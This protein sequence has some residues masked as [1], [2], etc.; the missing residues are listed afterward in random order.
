MARK[1]GGCLIQQT[2][3]G[4]SN[5]IATAWGRLLDRVQKDHPDF[6][7]LN[8]NKLRKT[9]SRF[10]RQIAGGEV[11][12]IFLA[13]GQATDDA[14]L[15]LYAARDFAQVFAA[16]AKWRDVLKPIFENVTTDTRTVIPLGKIDRIRELWRSDLKPEEIARQT[17]TSRATVYRYRPVRTEAP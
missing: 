5:K 6:R 4:R 9:S 3:A 1:D 2:P 14:L 8:F 16:Q 10:I 11:A 15:E 17:G 13:H 7:R 12:S